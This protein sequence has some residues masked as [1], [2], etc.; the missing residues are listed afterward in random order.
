MATPDRMGSQVDPLVAAFDQHYVHVYRYIRSRVGETAAEDLTQD[1]FLAVASS[2][3]LRRV[4]PDSAR[5]VLFGVATNLI[6]GYWRTATLRRRTADR[7]AHR[8]DPGLSDMDDAE[9]RLDAT[10]LGPALAE[11]LSALSDGERDVVLLFALAGL[12]QRE[13]ATALHL[14]A[15]AVRVRLFRG[16][17]KLRAHLDAAV[18]R[19]FPSHVPAIARSS[20]P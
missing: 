14:T 18:P 4:L 17:R 9:S 7:I 2:P 6:R 3:N 8:D 20:Q 10:A 5:P 15:V 19:H 13:I 12:G 1:T 16:R 11:G